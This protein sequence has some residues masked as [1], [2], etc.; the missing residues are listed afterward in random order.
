M[1]SRYKNRSVQ[2]CLIAD[3]PIALFFQEICSW[4][5]V[6][7]VVNTLLFWAKQTDVFSSWLFV[8]SFSVAVCFILPTKLFSPVY[9]WLCKTFIVKIINVRKICL[10]KNALINVF[11]V[12]LWNRADHYIFSVVSSSSLWPPYPYVIGGAIIFCPV[13]SFFLSSSIFLFLPRLISAATDWM[14][15]ILLHMA[16]P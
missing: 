2:N 7:L 13:V 12:A 9:E 15:T 10:M 4:Y 3:L 8:I 5:A 1:F 11:M 14:S 16:W 6:V